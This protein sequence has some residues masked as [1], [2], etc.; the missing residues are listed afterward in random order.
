MTKTYAHFL[1]ALFITVAFLG[2]TLA[3]FDFSGKA[4]LRKSSKDSQSVRREVKPPSE[5]EVN[6]KEKALANKK[7]CDSIENPIA[8]KFTPEQFDKFALNLVQEL[9]YTNESGTKFILGYHFDSPH[10]Y[11][12]TKNNGT[13]RKSKKIYLD[14]VYASTK[15]NLQ[16]AFAKGE[17][18]LLIR[19]APVVVDCGMCEGK[20]LVKTSEIITDQEVTDAHFADCPRCRGKKK[21]KVE[22]ELLYQVSL[23]EAP[24]V[25]EKSTPPSTPAE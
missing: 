14:P 13:I 4:S 11:S 21:S 22:V 7:T 10:F 17:V 15:E 23:K 6:V 5:D 19:K 8:V 9:Y 3:Q 12:D 20:G 25:S 1:A 2:Q 16:A 24:K 18:F